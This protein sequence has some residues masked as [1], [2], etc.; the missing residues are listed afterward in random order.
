MPY[1]CQVCGFRTSSHREAVDH[2]TEAHDRTDKLQCPRCLKT[3]SLSSDKGYNSSVAAAFVQHLQTHQDG[4]RKKC[5][6]CQL[7]F[8]D[9]GK[10]LRTHLEH[11]HGSFKGF[12]GLENYQYLANETPT[13][14]MRPNEIGIKMA[15]KKTTGPKLG[16]VQ[17]TAFAAQNLEDL[18]MY[19]VD[20]DDACKE[21]TRKMATSG[22]FK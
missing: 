7:A 10:S 18:A 6:K 14:M 13:K 17:Q 1:G 2:F 22:H 9:D 19:D 5:F 16:Q 15:P 3:Y 20:K 8:K 12:E 21:C 11:D 4:K